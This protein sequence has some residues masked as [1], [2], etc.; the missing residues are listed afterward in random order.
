MIFDIQALFFL[1]PLFRWLQ[2]VDKNGLALVKNVPCE[3]KKILEVRLQI[4]DLYTQYTNETL[5]K[6]PA[7]DYVQVLYRIISYRLIVV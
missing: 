7:M 5:F 4:E 1:P 6:L 3:D 2:A